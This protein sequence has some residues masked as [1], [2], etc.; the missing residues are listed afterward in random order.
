MQKFEWFDSLEVGVKVI[1]DDH[2]EMMKMLG[3]IQEAICVQ[4]LVT[5][6]KLVVEFIQLTRMHFINE[7]K[8]LKDAK[9][10]NLKQ[11]SLTHGKLMVR[12]IELG[13]IVRDATHIDEL[14]DCLHDLAG[15]LFH[16]LI[17]SDMEFKSYLQECGVA[18][19]RRF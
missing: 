9:F 10:P 4:S 6:K 15:F 14:G 5:T 13:K 12:A 2:R 19:Q 16:D 7:E 8:I 17:A 18:E 1:D 11:H 3:L